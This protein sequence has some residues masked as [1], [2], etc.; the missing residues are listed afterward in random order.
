MNGLAEDNP[1]IL[2]VAAT[3][4]PEAID[5]SLIRSGRF[6]YKIHVPM[7]DQAARQEIIINIVSKAIA[8]S[9]QGGFEIFDTLDAEELAAQAHDL[10]GA[11]ITEVFRRLK[12]GKATAEAVSGQKH[13][14]ITQQDTIRAIQDFPR[15]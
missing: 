4:N 2:V 5:P 9:E 10:S 15:Q 8:R 3:N 1:N 14:P 13:P 11:D 6:D 12:F 7:P